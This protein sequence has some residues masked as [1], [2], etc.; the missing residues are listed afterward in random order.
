[1][2]QR[3]N[4]AA[5]TDALIESSKEECVLSMEQRSNDVTMKDV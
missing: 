4:D 2:G 3:S 5:V 1:M